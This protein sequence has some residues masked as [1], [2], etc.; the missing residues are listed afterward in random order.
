MDA[1]ER[2]KSAMLRVEALVDYYKEH[3]NTSIFSQFKTPGDSITTITIED[4]KILLTYVTDCGDL[5]RP[6][7][8]PQKEI[9]RD[10]KL[11]KEIVELK[12]S[13]VEQESWLAGYDKGYTAG[14][15]GEMKAKK[16]LRD[17]LLG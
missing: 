14:R 17:F 9:E 3:P 15:D 13:I 6:E 12:Q 5:R 1:I 10:I 8:V 4:L 16:S 11:A 7:F 2:L